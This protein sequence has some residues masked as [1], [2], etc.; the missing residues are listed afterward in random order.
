M[1][2]WPARAPGRPLIP[3]LRA[4]HVRLSVFEELWVLLVGDAAGGFGDYF[5]ETQFPEGY[6]INNEPLTDRPEIE[7]VSEFLVYL[8]VIITSLQM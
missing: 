1:G 5:V 4:S 6:W 2:C 8:D 3:R 7:I